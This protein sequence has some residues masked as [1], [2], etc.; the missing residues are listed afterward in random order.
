MA[1]G[2]KSNAG[3]QVQRDM[4][5]W[6]LCFHWKPSLKILLQPQLNC[7]TNWSWWLR[8]WNNTAAW[9]SKI[10]S[11]SCS[12]WWAFVQP[13]VLQR[14]ALI[15]LEVSQLFSLLSGSEKPDQFCDLHYWDC[16]PAPC[17]RLLLS[18]Q[19]SAGGK[20]KERFCISGSICIAFLP[21]F[22]AQR[23]FCLCSR[24]N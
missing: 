11:W 9:S 23:W 4:Q 3:M 20:G 7:A 22:L 13:S 15:A 1:T 8:L 6:M 14:Q 12:L 24:T 18:W 5:C 19:L 21:S 16:Q 17:E 10:K 2:F